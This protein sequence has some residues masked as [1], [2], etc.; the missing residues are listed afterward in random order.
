[1]MNLFKGAMQQ[2]QIAEAAL[3]SRDGLECS[4]YAWQVRHQ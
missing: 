4:A 1:M 2:R 3:A